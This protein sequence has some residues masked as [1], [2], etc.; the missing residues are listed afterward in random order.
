MLCF[1]RTLRRR[2]L[3]G[4][5]ANEP[6]LVLVVL[7]SMVG[8]SAEPIVLALTMNRLVESL[9]DALFKRDLSYLA[10]S[11]MEEECLDQ[12]PWAPNDLNGRAL[13]FFP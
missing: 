2:E 12:T 1:D 9:T 11:Y 10:V 5:R 13:L 3:E 8:V 6:E 4:V 7:V